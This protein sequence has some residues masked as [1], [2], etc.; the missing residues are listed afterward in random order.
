MVCVGFC[1]GE[2][3][4][5]KCNLMEKK[6]PVFWRR[7]EEDKIIWLVFIRNEIVFNL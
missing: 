1:E 2:E 3:G 6:H 7:D 4:K 5:S